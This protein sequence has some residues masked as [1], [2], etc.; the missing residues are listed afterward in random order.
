M[1]SCERIGWQANRLPHPC[2]RG[3]GM[4]GPYGSAFWS[5]AATTGT[6]NL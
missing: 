6:I 2:G 1:R 3:P 5:A 4:P